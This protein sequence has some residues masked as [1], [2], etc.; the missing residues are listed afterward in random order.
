MSEFTFTSALSP[1]PLIKFPVKVRPGMLRVVFINNEGRR[2]EATE[3]LR[4][5]K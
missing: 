5:E 1:N 3:P 2:W 4:P